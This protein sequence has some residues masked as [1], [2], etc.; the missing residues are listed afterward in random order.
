MMAEH[1]SS[2]SPPEELHRRALELE[3]IGWQL[4][5]D[6]WGEWCI[7]LRRPNDRS[8]GVS[9]S[10]WPT[11]EED[12]WEGREHTVVER[13]NSRPYRVDSPR[14]SRGRPFKSLR[15]AETVFIQEARELA[16]GSGSPEADDR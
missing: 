16:P 11:V 14:F 7:H 5:I 3:K 10:Y 2:A 9:L 4:R 15:E 12:V 6:T 13:P 8:D 1:D